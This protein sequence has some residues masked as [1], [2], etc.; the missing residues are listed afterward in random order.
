MKVDGAQKCIGCRM[1]HL[2]IPR[3]FRSPH[4]KGSRMQLSS[5]PRFKNEQGKQQQ[6]DSFGGVTFHSQKICASPKWDSLVDLDTFHLISI[7]ARQKVGIMNP[8]HVH[9]PIPLKRSKRS[10]S[11][12]WKLLATNTTPFRKQ[13]PAVDEKIDSHHGT[14]HWKSPWFQIDSP[15]GIGQTILLLL[16]GRS[17]GNASI[18]C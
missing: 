2:S 16:W 6:A 5:T 17:M 12:V 15:L 9:F 7:C 10:R 14:L 1:T 3:S 11:F 13:E 18:I 8:K 4:S